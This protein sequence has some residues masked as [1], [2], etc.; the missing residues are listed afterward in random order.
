MTQD[1]LAN[2]E[3]RMYYIADRQQV[4]TQ[5][6]TNS[7]TP[8]Y[9]AMELQAPTFNDSLAKVQS[10]Q[11]A[12]TSPMDIP[13]T[14]GAGSTNGTLVLNRT[15]AEVSPTGNTVSLEDETRK[16]AE[17]AMDYQLATNVYKSIGGMLM[18]AAGK[19]N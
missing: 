11:M 13:S 6:I 18:K 14:R 19:S 2:L 12:Q 3:S 5:N 4:L 7:D 9:R 17:N 16:A 8:G 10:V 1:V 15:P